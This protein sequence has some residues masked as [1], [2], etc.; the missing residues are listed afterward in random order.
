[1][2]RWLQNIVWGVEEV[3]ECDD[4][5]ELGRLTRHELSKLDQDLQANMKEISNCQS[6]LACTRT[7][8]GRLLE[9]TEAIIMESYDLPTQYSDGSEKPTEKV[10]ECNA[11][12]FSLECS[13]NNET[14]EKKRFEIRQESSIFIETLMEVMN[15]L[16]NRVYMLE[17]QV[18]CQR[19]ERDLLLNH[20][21][22]NTAEFDPLPPDE[23]PPSSV[24]IA[25]TETQNVSV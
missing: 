22:R 24:Q 25:T 11:V 16:L 13:P 17:V 10:D 18:R 3:E 4:E 12:A 20:I 2:F 9:E 7:K 14:L 15:G 6:E 23:Q 1:M 19:V 8:I 21:L 5:I